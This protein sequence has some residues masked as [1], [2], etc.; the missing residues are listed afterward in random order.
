MG[1]LQGEVLSPVL[2]SMYINDIE[3]NLKNQT[4]LV[5]IFN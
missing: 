4:S 5:L 1:L 2:F 3:L